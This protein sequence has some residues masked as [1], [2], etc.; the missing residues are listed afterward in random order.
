MKR[1]NNKKSRFG[2]SVVD[3]VLFILIASCLLSSVFQDQIR[4][5][6]GDE[7]GVAVE[8]TFLI[9]NVTVAA[10][11]HPS[12]GEE[13]ILAETG[14]S[15]GVITS[16]E[17][18][19]NLFGNVD[20]PDDTVEILTLTCKAQVSAWETESGYVAGEISL[21]PGARMS[22]ETPTASFVMT[23]TMVKQTEKAE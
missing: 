18:K 15:L 3:L 4:S 13:I 1:N 10:R 23:V 2:F 9:E 16:V 5:F 20:N 19:R 17:E 14:K 6:L 8:Y 11:N 22:V 12:Y 7:E 21:K